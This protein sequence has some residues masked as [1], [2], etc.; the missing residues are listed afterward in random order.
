MAGSLDDNPPR[1]I[2]RND[3]D[4]M[5]YGSSREGESLIARVTDIAE[6][7]IA[8]CLRRLADWLE[9]GR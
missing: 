3:F 4:F 1:I 5:V 2:A 8:A 6:A 7:D 9:R